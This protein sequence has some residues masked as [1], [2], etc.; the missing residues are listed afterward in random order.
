MKKIK[1]PQFINNVEIIDAGSEGMSI[2]KPEEKVV[3]IP[4][5]APGDIVDI[6]VFKKKSNC[7]DGKIVNIVKESDKRVKPV[8]QH[9]GLCGGCKW[10]HLDYQWQLYYK[11]K[12]VKDNLDR[13]AKIEYPEI[14]PILGCEKQYY[15]RNKVSRTANGLLTALPLAPILKSSARVSA[16]IFRG[17][18]IG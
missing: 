5:G 17:F 4:F 11:Q 2:A 16:T 14:T 18:S 7:F 3:F 9:F 8:C 6:Q 12:Q 13:I 1:Q 15:Y 10:Q